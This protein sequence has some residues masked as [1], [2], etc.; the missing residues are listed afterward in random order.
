MRRSCRRSTPRAWECAATQAESVDRMAGCRA[1]ALT[2]ASGVEV[3]VAIVGS[4]ARITQFDEWRS[5]RLR[6]GTEVLRSGTGDRIRCV[7]WCPSPVGL[8]LSH[9]SVGWRLRWRIASGVSRSR[10]FCGCRV[11]DSGVRR[12]HIRA[13]GQRISSRRVSGSGRPVAVGVWRV[14]F[15][16]FLRSFHTARASGRPR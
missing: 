16:S 9:P 7:G 6:S 11:T 4:R 15:P 1:R 10:P 13:S 2:L 8:G 14:T 12:C 3:R 5:L